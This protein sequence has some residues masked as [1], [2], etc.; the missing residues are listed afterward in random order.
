MYNGFASNCITINDTVA[1]VDNFTALQHLEWL[2][3]HYTTDEIILDHP[4]YA[5]Y[6]TVGA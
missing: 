3:K 2:K 5:K 6:L 1:E 4:D